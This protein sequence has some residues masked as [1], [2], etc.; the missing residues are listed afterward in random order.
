M[1]TLNMKEVPE[2]PETTRVVSNVISKTVFHMLIELVHVME[3][4]RIGDSLLRPR[5]SP[6]LSFL[7]PSIPPLW[8]S[9]TASRQ[10]RS[11]MPILSKGRGLKIHTTACQRA[12]SSSSTADIDFPLKDKPRPKPE[13][14]RSPYRQDSP[15]DDV[16]RNQLDG[17]LDSAFNIP[18][19][20]KRNSTNTADEPSDVMMETAYRKAMRNRQPDKSY[21]DIARK[22]QF[23]SQ[24][25]AGLDRLTPFSRDALQILGDTRIPAKR[26][27]RTVRSRP[28]VG[29]TIEV[30]PERGVDVG[31]A[32]S[33]LNIACALNRVRQDLSSQRFHE[34]P[35]LK[36]KRLKSERWRK[37]FKE[38]FRATV[39]RVKEMRRKGW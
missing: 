27:K 9:K 34:R 38:S 17:I 18:D 16:L 6:L 28:A 20:A 22:M 13:T 10:V 15:T 8:R 4:R 5:M 11:R 36:K 2:D 26:A 19:P 24:D 29:R 21:H 12:Q 37:M 33:N 1:N 35:G 39:M 7:A 31:R 14:L 3:L 25:P 32:L 23:P 30:L